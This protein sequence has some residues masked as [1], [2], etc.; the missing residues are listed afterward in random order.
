MADQNADGAQKKCYVSGIGTT[1]FLPADLVGG[2]VGLGLG[3]KMVEAYDFVA[4]NYQH[5]DADGRPDQI[6]L[7]GFSRG[8]YLARNLAGLL[9]SYGIEPLEPGTDEANRTL[10][11]NVYSAYHRHTDSSRVWRRWFHRRFAHPVSVHFLGVWDTVGSLGVP[12]EFGILDTLDANKYRF[13]D[14]RLNDRVRHARHAVALDER[15]GPF[16][17]TLW[18]FRADVRGSTF[19]QVW[20]PG[21]HGSVGGSSRQRATGPGTGHLS[22]V[23]LQWM[24]DQAGEHGIAFDQVQL[25]PAPDGGF[26]ENLRSFYR[27]VNPHP[28]AVP[29]L[30]ADG[31][32]ATRGEVHASAVHRIEVVEGYRPQTALIGDPAQAEV[33]VAAGEPWNDTGIWLTPGAYRL[34]A[35]GE[36]SGSGVRSGPSGTRTGGARLP[37]LLRGGVRALEVLETGIRAATGND[38]ARVF[39]TR[40]VCTD[41][42][43]DAI[44]WMCLVGV[45]ADGELDARTELPQPHT[46]FRIGDGV[47]EFEVFRPGYLYAFANDAWGSYSNNV[48]SVQLAVR[49]L[50]H[51]TPPVGRA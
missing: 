29:R 30:A 40:R 44:A 25:D 42:N 43:G 45:I 16:A 3:T 36:W 24:L 33:P 8:A 1:G 51:R 18:T 41:D 49:R 46:T 10:A 38:Q 19:R 15:R 7:V 28:R 26:T 20:F 2:A 23:T 35:R 14:T 32:D 27:F 12:A 37:A 11:E 4:R 47:Q 6:S 31:N 9:T 21:N 34:S 17:P 48:G 39:G 5:E 22:D 50:H 13:Y